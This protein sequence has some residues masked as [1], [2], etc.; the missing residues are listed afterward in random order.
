MLWTP[1]SGPA[2]SAPG[3][4]RVEF[5]HPLA[6]TAVYERAALGERR[7]VHAALAKVLSG[8]EHVDRRVWHQAMAS[9]SG[10]EEVAV[11]LEASARRAQL[12]AGHA[13]AAT[14]FERSAELTQDRARIAPRLAAAAEA[15]WDAGQPARSLELVA[16][17]LSLSDQRLRA[18]LLY[19]RGVI[20]A[21]CGSMGD[22]VATLLEGA[23]DAEPA[24]ALAMLHEA[25]EVVGAIGQLGVV[26][27]IGERA[28]DLPA[29]GLRAEFSKRILVGASQL[30]AGELEKAR[31]TLDDALA[32]ADELDDDPRAQIWAANAAGG[33]PGRGLQHTS[34]AVEIARRQGLFSLL[35]LALRAS[36]EGAASRWP[37]RPRLLGRTGGLRA[38][39]RTRSRRGVAPRHDGLCR[40]DP[41]GRDRVARA[42]RERARDRATQRRHLSGRR[43][44]APRSGCSSSRSGGRRRPQP[45]CSRSPPPTAAT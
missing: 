12:R 23:G 27:E 7:R 35:P 42:R 26:R 39:G 22:A 34:K 41:G 21:R 15:A 5:R 19:L 14:A 1:P 36:R 45:R 24:L 40:G 25:A 33:E 32:L 3:P 4:P 31:A 37:P 17:A 29:D 10:D 13:S 2:W 20:E 8:D 43:R 28:A 9:V 11:A 18:R 30:V 6:R 38:I 16:R 44:F